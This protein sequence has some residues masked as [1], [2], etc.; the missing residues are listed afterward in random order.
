MT[1]LLFSN[2]ELDRHRSVQK[3]VRNPRA[4]WKEKLGRHKQRN[5][6][7]ES[8]D[9]ASYLIYLRQNLNDER[10]FSC[11]LQLVRR[12]AKP[13]SLVR[14]N[15]ASHAHGEIRFR[16]HIHR[17]SLEAISAGKKIDSNAEETNRYRTLEG[18]LAC[19]LEDCG[20]QGVSAEY[21]QWDMFD[22]N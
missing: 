15:G 12:G 3:T 5:F 22:G 6:S 2:D 18:A 11:G 13:L 9:G 1:D 14:Y 21:D 8:L 16:C 7:A 20:V 17:A 10:D 19:L 4:R